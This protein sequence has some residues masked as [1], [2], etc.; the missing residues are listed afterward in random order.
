MQQF[1]TISMKLSQS[2]KLL[3]FLNLFNLLICG[4]KIEACIKLQKKSK[5]E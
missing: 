4:K 5:Y 2:K 3:Q 1:K